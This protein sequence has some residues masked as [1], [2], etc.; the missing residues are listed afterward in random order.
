MKSNKALNILDK[1]SLAMIYFVVAISPF[2]S[3][4]AGLGLAACF[5]LA[6]LFPTIS[7]IIYR[8]GVFK[9]ALK[10]NIYKVVLIFFLYSLIS[11][12]WAVSPEQSFKLWYRMVLFFIGFICLYEFVRQFNDGQRKTL[13]VTLLIGFLVALVAANV[14]IISGGALSEFF[15]SFK[16]KEYHFELTDLNRGATYL[17]IIFWCVFAQVVVYKRFLF[18]ALLAFLTLLTI[19]RLESQSASMAFILSFLTF[20][21][22]LVFGKKAIKSMML[23]AIFAVISVAAVSYKM[24]PDIIFKN[25]P[26]IPNSAS[27]YR[28][29][30]WD[31]TAGLAMEKPIWG[32][33]FNASRAIPISEGEYVLNGRHPLPLHPHNN[34]LQVWV[35]LGCVGLFIFILFLLAQLQSIESTTHLQR[36]NCR[37]GF[38]NDSKSLIIRKLMDNMPVSMTFGLFCT[39]FAIGETGYGIWQNWWVAGGLLSAVIINSN[40]S[41]N[42]T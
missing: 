9:Q 13:S 34:V 17:A 27:E 7:S 29:Y 6:A 36:S 40:F 11:A 28:L 16:A 20:P 23:L 33:G 14:E 35:E 15:R 38:K 21:L 22:I 32:W 26:D 4:F 39:Y 10:S 8:R 31:F 18:A 2:L 30:I 24:Q 42:N 1:S 3:L 41:K 19:I 5:V 37:T 25:I 12:A